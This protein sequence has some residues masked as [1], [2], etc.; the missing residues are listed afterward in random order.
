MN[1]F[2][3]QYRGRTLL[4]TAV[5]FSLVWAQA[6]VQSNRI[7]IGQL[8]KRGDVYYH[9][10]TNVPYTGDVYAA[11]CEES[12]CYLSGSMRNGKFHGS[13]RTSDFGYD[14]TGTYKDGKKDGDW[15]YHTINDDE[16]LE[17]K[18]EYY[19]DGVK[20]NEWKQ[21]NS[22]WKLFDGNGKPTTI[23]NTSYSFEKGILYNK[24]KTV[25]VDAGN[26][27]GA[28]TI[29]N[30]V[31]S[32]E[33]RAFS[34][35]SGLTSIVIPNSVT[36]IGEG[37]FSGCN[38]L[39]SVTI[40]SGLT[41]LNGFSFSHYHNLTAVEVASGNPRFTSEGGVLFSKDKTILIGYPAGREG[42]Y[43]IPNGVTAIGN[44]AFFGCTGLTS[45]NIP[46]SVK[47]IGKEAFSG[48][49]GLI[50]I[51]IPSGVT[52]IEYNAFNRCSGLISIIIKNPTPPPI[53]N[54]TFS[55]FK[56][57]ACTLYVPQGSAY[58]QTSGWN[59]FKHIG[60]MDA[61]GKVLQVVSAPA[62][63]FAAARVAQEKVAKMQ[64]TIDNYKKQLAECDVRKSDQCAFLMH[65][66]GNIYYQQADLATASGGKPD[67]SMAIQTYQR[68]LNEYPSSS[69]SPSAKN[70]LTDMEIKSLP[71]E[72]QQA[73]RQKAQQTYLTTQMQQNIDTYKKQL[74][75]CRGDQCAVAMY[76]L[77]NTYY[78]QA[79]INA[80]YVGVAKTDYSMVVQTFQRLL[81]E[82][83]DS[84]YSPIVKQQLLKIETTQKR[85][86]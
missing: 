6:T 51:I 2:T 66:L 17:L 86:Y 58:A 13:Y 77:G 32:I 54:A 65:T 7:D 25:L 14:E 59:E 41:T 75:E 55:S 40:P 28:Y 11:E 44:R 82:Y 62:A 67:Y 50:S 30:G 74:A 18:I 76:M 80:M 53:E 26:K 72:Q 34:Y 61:N 52:S 3:R 9:P 42:T 60:Y 36:S 23:N 1:V 4:L 12:D 45:I 31:T 22:V 35:C 37:T 46:N 39:T 81:N 73:A 15:V 56:V 79:N 24:N 16:R 84:P 63:S 29:P 69:L 68:L 33:R 20:Y 8:Q 43:T 71:L 78:Q 64:Q 83:P 47:N 21:D 10:A 70:I 38:E 19:K 49:S 5:V 48:C 85:G 57:K 27:Q